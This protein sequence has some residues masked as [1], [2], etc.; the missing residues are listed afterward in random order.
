[1]SG[2][3]GRSRPSIITLTAGDRRI[4]TRIP[5]LLSAP[6]G[7]QLGRSARKHL[8]LAIEQQRPREGRIAGQVVSAVPTRRTGPVRRQLRGFG[9]GTQL[10]RNPEEARRVSGR[11]TP[12]GADA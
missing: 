11:A 4:E 1:M 3:V 2:R 6:D 8:A 5:S 9:D 12:A 7:A 10:P